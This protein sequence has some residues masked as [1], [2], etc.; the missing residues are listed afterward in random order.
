MHVAESLSWACHRHVGKISFNQS[1]PKNASKALTITVLAI[2]ALQ[3]VSLHA[4]PVTQLGGCV[5]SLMQ[6]ESLTDSFDVWTA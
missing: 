4:N 5:G 2:T 6:V 3:S 1:W